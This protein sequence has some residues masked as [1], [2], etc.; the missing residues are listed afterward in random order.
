MI[1]YY[2]ERHI[3]RLDQRIFPIHIYNLALSEWFVRVFPFPISAWHLLAHHC[4][5]DDML[6]LNSDS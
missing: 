5:D 1:P 6:Q 2:K 4:P 3:L